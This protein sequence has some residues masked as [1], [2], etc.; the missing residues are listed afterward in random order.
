M[1]R[2]IDVIIPVDTHNFFHQISRLLHIRFMKRDGNQQVIWPF[3]QNFKTK[4]KQDTFYRKGM[5]VLTAEFLQVMIS[6]QDLCFSYR[7]LIYILY[8]RT[9]FASTVFT[10]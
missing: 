9:Y 10:N 5:I 6:Q 1:G 4:R 2:N 8:G 7:I 3:A